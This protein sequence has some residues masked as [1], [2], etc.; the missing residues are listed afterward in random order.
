MPVTV[1]GRTGRQSHLDVAEIDL[2]GRQDKWQDDGLTG[3]R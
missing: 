1:S 3:W 2:S